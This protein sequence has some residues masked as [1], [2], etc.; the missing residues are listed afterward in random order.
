MEL[1]ILVD[2]QAIQGRKNEAAPPMSTKT[3]V[4]FSQPF[5]AQDWPLANSPEAGPVQGC[6]RTTRTYMNSP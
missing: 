1:P 2:T 5:P 6:R 4:Q 3:E